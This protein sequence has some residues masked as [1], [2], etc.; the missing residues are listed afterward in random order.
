L[1]QSF[2]NL[3]YPFEINPLSFYLDLVYE[4]TE[5]EITYLPYSLRLAPDTAH[6][7]NHSGGGL[8]QIMVLYSAIDAPL[9]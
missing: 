6:K 4:K 1:R 5:D 8:T 9:I 3:I 7:S 2:G